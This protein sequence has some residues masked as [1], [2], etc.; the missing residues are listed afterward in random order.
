MSLYVKTIGAGEPVVM[1]HGWGMHGGIWENTAA[2]LA[3]NFA[4][5][6]VDLPGHGES[7]PPDSF[8]LDNVV[9][10]LDAK[11]EQPVTVI[12]WSLG[13]II[14]QRWASR[15]SQKIKQLVLVA[16]TP[17]FA[18]HDDWDSGMPQETL[19]QFAMELE[20]NFAAT[21]R[22][23]LAL[24]VRGS[25]SER[26]LLSVLRELLFIRGE[27]HLNALRGGLDILRDADLRSELQAIN[28]PALVIAG[29]RD[30]LT[31]LAASHF[32]AQAMPNARM[33]EIV[34]AAHAP[35]LSH[36]D[37]FIEHVKS[38]LYE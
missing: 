37:I 28:Q 10:Q 35:F 18:Q 16:T 25:E 30:K 7:S 31:P 5:H 1:L 3:E 38:F 2:R 8:T 26:E 6:V 4:V 22:R 24:Q 9:D 27:P 11:F 17:S 14:A 19:T 13:G 23:F 29:Q 21:L 33:V 20:N 12:G 15:A 36:Q 34:G 32:I